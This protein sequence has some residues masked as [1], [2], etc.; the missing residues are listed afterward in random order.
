MI[1][2]R[3]ISASADPLPL[4]SVPLQVFVV[5]LNLTSSLV[6]LCDADTITTYLPRTF[7]PTDPLP[8]KSIRAGADLRDNIP[9]ATESNG[10]MGWGSD[11][12]LTSHNTHRVGYYTFFFPSHRETKQ[13]RLQN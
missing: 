8:A 4:L 2:P 11:S 9:A 1:G 12:A 10:G 6:L 5:A 3:G 13:N 7:K